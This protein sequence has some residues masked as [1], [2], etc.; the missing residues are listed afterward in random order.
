M[1]SPKSG[2]L[3]IKPYVGGESQLADVDRII[4]LAANE[5]ALGPSPLAMAACADIASLLHRYPDGGSDALRSGLAETFNVDPAK[6]VC[7]A[8]SDELIALL[9]K[10]YAGEG[11]ELLYSEHGFLMY[12]ISAM[13]CGATPVAAPESKLR[14]DC[15]AMLDHVTDKT[16]L[17]FLA[18]PNNPTGSYLS[19]RELEDFHSQLPSDVIL[20][21]DAAYAEYATASDYEPGIDL[22][23]KSDNVVMLR[24]FSKAFGLAALRLGWAYSSPEITDILHR[25]RGPFNVSAV[26]QVVGVEALKDK[27]H[28]DE[29]IRLNNKLLPEFIDFINSIGL[30]AVPSQG[31]F[32][33]VDFGKPA[34]KADTFLRSK[35]IFNARHCCLRPP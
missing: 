14:T 18:N 15:Q 23:N 34:D 30:K 5:S 20:V 25:V 7:G 16:K 13:S 1:L 21:I 12:K 29:T 2:I 11:D 26:S 9:V 19:Q 35:G 3:S 8:G 4:R 22:V 33:M 24:T 10:A 27:A 31:N 32:V 17:V 6:I 28:F